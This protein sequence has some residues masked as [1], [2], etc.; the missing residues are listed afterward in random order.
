MKSTN[1]KTENVLT[2]VSSRVDA[3]LANMRSQ[4]SHRG[5][6][7]FAL[8][9]TMSREHTWD[10]AVQFQVQIFREVAA[11]G[12]LSGATKLPHAQVKY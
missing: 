7:V 9:A 4:P 11:V 1:V 12:T 6:L 10:V 8:D 2:N 3:F 5:N